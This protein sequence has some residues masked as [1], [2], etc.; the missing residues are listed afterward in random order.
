MNDGMP[1]SESVWV[2]RL[3]PEDSDAEILR[4]LPEDPFFIRGSHPYRLG[5]QRFGRIPCGVAYERARKGEDVALEA[6]LVWIDSIDIVRFEM[7]KV[8]FTMECEG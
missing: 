4:V 1:G 8:E 5:I 2:S 3:L 6:R 7:T